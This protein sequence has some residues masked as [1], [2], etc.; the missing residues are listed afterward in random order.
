VPTSLHGHTVGRPP[1]HQAA[2]LR[3]KTV[4]LALLPLGQKIVPVDAAPVDPYA[5]PQ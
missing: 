5:L 4:P 2:R 1:D 3:W